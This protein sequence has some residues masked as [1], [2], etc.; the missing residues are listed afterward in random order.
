M[1]GD[2]DEVVL[3][4]VLKQILEALERIERRQRIGLRELD[5]IEDLVTPKSYPRTTAVSVGQT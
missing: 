1:R 3:V 2:D 4:L 5:E